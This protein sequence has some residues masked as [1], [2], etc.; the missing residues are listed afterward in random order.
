VLPDFGAGGAIWSTGGIRPELVAAMIDGARQ[1]GRGPTAPSR[2]RGGR[3]G[4]YSAFAGLAVG[5]FMG[6]LDGSMVTSMLPVLTR[7]LQVD[8][9]T[10]EWLLTIYMLIQSGLMLSFGRLGD[11]R[12]HKPIYVGGLVV[13]MVGSVLSGLAPT[14]ALLVAARAVTALGSAAMWANSAAILT[15]AFPSAQRGRALG[16][17]SMMVQLGA[18]CGPPLGGLVAGTLGWRAI[19]WIS[20]P[21][22]L[23]ALVLSLRFIRRDEPS[24][25][26][27]RFDLAGAALYV[28]GLMAV[29]VALNQGH[30]WGW[31]SPGVLGCLAL[32]LALLAGFAALE[33]RLTSPML[34]LGLFRARAFAS[35]VVTAVLNFACTSSI[36]FLLPL[37]LLLGRGLAPAEAGLILVS[38][39]LVMASISIVSGTLSDRIGSRLPATLGMLI[40]SLGLFLLS[41]VDAA[42]PLPLLVA[43][44]AT[45]G[46]GVGLFNAPNSS[47]VMGAVPSSRR[48]VAA[49][50]LSTARTLGNTLGLGLAGAIFTT[51]LAGRELTNP[52]VLVQAVGAGFATASALALL[53]AVTSAARPATPR[54]VDTAT[55]RR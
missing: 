6:P 53:G 7:E 26:G 25:R 40:L 27:E 11:L 18:S 23:V 10:T 44:L 4:H 24:G 39:P 15:H 45:A 36:V 20:V 21:V 55:T 12:G 3:F 52:T 34:D 31:G 9:A 2:S 30:A 19:F 16:L 28:L 13:F 33:S 17:Q 29:L 48:G 37:Y 49:A 14:P 5:A 32:G 8:I 51:G 38:Q 1:P 46:V 41:R 47:A 50:I 42:T 22:T 54:K 43:A 35:P